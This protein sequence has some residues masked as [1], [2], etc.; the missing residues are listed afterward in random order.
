M[1]GT[2]QLI[3]DFPE[4]AQPKHLPPPYIAHPTIGDRE[5]IMVGQAG[6]LRGPDNHGVSAGKWGFGRYVFLSV[7]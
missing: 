7:I 1:L 4:D 2:I 5:V 3:V 6:K